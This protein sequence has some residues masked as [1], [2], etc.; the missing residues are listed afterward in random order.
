M[1]ASSYAFAI[2]KATGAECTEDGKQCRPAGF[3]GPAGPHPVQSVRIVVIRTPQM[4]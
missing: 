4:R 2:H 1:I 3:R